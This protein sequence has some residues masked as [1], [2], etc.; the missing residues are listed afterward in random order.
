[1]YAYIHI[2]QRDFFL[3][4]VQLFQSV[5]CIEKSDILEKISKN[6]VKNLRGQFQY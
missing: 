5:Q 2:E 1:M 3:I 4:S 6:G